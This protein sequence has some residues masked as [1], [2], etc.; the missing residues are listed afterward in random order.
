M[1][2]KNQNKSRLAGFGLSGGVIFLEEE[3]MDWADSYA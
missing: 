3:D 1:E 2:R